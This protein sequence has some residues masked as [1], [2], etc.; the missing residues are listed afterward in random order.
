[1]A[2]S[3]VTNP[4][5]PKTVDVAQTAGR[6]TIYITLAKLWFIVSGYGIEFIL[7]RLL[8]KEEFGL[9]KVVVG[10]VSIINAVI[11]EI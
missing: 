3:Q 4:P 1:M 10:A 5:V 11:V 6:G 2:Q 8:A 7:P 9:Y